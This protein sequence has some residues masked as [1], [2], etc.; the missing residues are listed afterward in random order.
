M[1]HFI[2]DWPVNR[3]AGAESWLP[4][5]VKWRHAPMGANFLFR[6]QSSM[7]T[8]PTPHFQPPH[9]TPA[10]SQRQ[11]TLTDTSWQVSA[12]K[13]LRLPFTF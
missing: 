6:P 1:L 4:R 11:E 12:L 10:D 8:A 9:P 2:T 7:H 5:P 3:V 13:K